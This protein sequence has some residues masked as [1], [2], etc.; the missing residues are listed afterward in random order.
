MSVIYTTNE[1]S[2]VGRQSYCW[3]EY[4]REG[5]MVLKSRCHRQKFFDGDENVW[6]RDETQVD[7]WDIDDSAMPEWLREYL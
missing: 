6:D 7:S 3:N 4:R 2:G 5:D 1:W